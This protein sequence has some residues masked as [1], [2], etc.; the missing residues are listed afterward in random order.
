MIVIAIEHKDG[1]ALSYFNG[2]KLK[3]FSSFEMT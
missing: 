2:D 1:S 3:V